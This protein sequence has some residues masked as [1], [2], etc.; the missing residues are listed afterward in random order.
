MISEVIIRYIAPTVIKIIPFNFTLFINPSSS[1]PF[2]KKKDII[3][4]AGNIIINTF[5][6][7]TLLTNG[8]KRINAASQP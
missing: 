4:I 1:W 8:S 6:F 5:P 3:D 7:F 2:D